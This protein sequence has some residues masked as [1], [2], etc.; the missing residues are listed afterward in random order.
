ME[1]VLSRLAETLNP[2]LM[3]FDLGEHRR[4]VFGEVAQ[5]DDDTAYV[6]GNALLQK[7]DAGVGHDGDPFAGLEFGCSFAA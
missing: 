7:M 4:R 5:S 2:L 6:V 1:F 3:E